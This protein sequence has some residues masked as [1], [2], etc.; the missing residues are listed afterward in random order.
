LSSAPHLSQ[1]SFFI[2]AAGTHLNYP[3]ATPPPPY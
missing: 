1:T 2:V 3:L